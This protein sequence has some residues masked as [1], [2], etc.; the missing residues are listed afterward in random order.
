MTT[1][2]D[3]S[4]RS[5][6]PSPPGDRL[7]PAETEEGLVEPRIVVSRLELPTATIV[8]V[9]LTLAIIWLLSVLWT[10]LLLMGIAALIATA[11]NPVVRRLEQRGW[12]RQ[13]AVTL[14]VLAA[15]A[16]FGLA[17]WLMIPTAIDEGKNLAA[18]LPSYVD[19]GERFL[20]DYPEVVQR[21]RD[22]ANRG[23]ASPG[24]FFAG[25]L[26]F[27]SSLVQSVVNTVVVLALTIY[28]L[29]DGHRV[30]DWLMRYVPVTQRAKIRRFLPEVSKVVSG[31][32]VGQA[33][34]SLLFGVTAFLVLSIAGVP[35]PLLL[36][37]LAALMDAIPIAGI[38]IATVPAVLLALTVSWDAAIVV[39]VAYM[40]YQQ[41]ENYLIVPR[42]YRGTLQISSLAVLIAV[43]IGGQLLGIV[44]VLVALPIAATVPVIER[45]WHTELLADD[46]S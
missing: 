38:L 16:A 26:R 2:A 3:R 25:V 34:T 45:I 18:N 4:P 39:F 44:G 33:I 27:G 30:I 32:V 1:P 10:Q 11:L 8:K 42:I 41:V 20:Q 43:L 17:G 13:L 31:Y 37:L 22:G 28:L 5:E 35:Q 7:V 23:S 21:L 29:V 15:I 6:P 40:V 24:S 19:R 9:V 36:A 12:S 46:T 14:I